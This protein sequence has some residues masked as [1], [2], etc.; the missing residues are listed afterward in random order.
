MS[1]QYDANGVPLFPM[2]GNPQHP[3]TE[4]LSFD[5]AAMIHDS[6]P[7]AGTAVK[8]AYVAPQAAPGMSTT[9]KA[10]I[11]IGVLAVGFMVAK[12]QRWI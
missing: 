8:A 7:A 11:A 5:L 10:L 6:A 9:T 2:T 3:G 1:P 4:R 12:S